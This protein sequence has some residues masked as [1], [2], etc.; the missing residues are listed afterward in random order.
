MYITI[1]SNTFD[2]H[3]GFHS[4]NVND[5]IVYFVCNFYF[6]FPFKSKLF[7]FK[8]NKKKHVSV[9]KKYMKYQQP[10]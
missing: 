4:I 6:N 10:L 2:F 8:K 3:L 1:S 5:R 7:R 9:E